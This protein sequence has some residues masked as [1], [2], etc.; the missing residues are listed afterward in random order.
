M[1]RKFSL[2]ALVAA[3]LLVGGLSVGSASAA[4]L[5]GNCCADLE[6]RIAELEATTARKGNRKVSLTISGWVGEQVLWWDDGS[7][8]GTYVTGLGTT[9]ASHVTFAGQATIM[10]GWY[11][12]YVLQL[13]MDEADPLTTM[14]QNV[15][16]GPTSIAP[17]MGTPDVFYS[18]WFVKSDHLGKVSV[19]LQSSAGDNAAI[20]VD[21]SGSLV[22]ANWVQ[23]DN[24][25][26]FIR[27]KNG[28]LSSL[29]WG[30]LGFCNV[31]FGNAGDCVG[32]PENLVR[33][34][35]PT[36]AGFSVSADWGQDSY[37]DVYARYSG[38]YNGIKV[39]AVT[40]WSQ[41][42]GCHGNQTQGEPFG[43]AG[44]GCIN[45]P[46]G[47]DSDGLNPVNV[48][49]DVGYWQSGLYVE[50]VATG[51]WVL[52]NYGREHLSDMPTGVNG[53]F[54][55]TNL[56]QLNSNPDHWYIKAGLRERWSQLGHTV[57]Y[58]FYGDRRDMIGALAV[59]DFNIV[60]SRTRQYGL[61]VVQEVDAAAMSFWLQWDHEKASVSCGTP[62]AGLTSTNGCA[63]NGDD[64]GATNLGGG[65]DAI[66]IV[67]G[68][69][70]IN[71]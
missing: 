49:G 44:S 70:L 17:G 28:A 16:I 13:E 62:Q 67:K 1:M 45:S 30:S 21:G 41:T 63:L 66:N 9:L 47:T 59:E 34:D 60:G 65:F 61:G 18:Y 55:L 10:P 15:N 25:A 71:F 50:H 38:E 26:F 40:G 56:G 11:A 68:G 36:W 46:F 8:K 52:A 6:E 24:A 39:A 3:G 32:T 31:G 43:F 22:P 2:S 20:L 5:G 58:G 33:Y 19:G 29:T 53:D 64:V 14:S 12:G 27:G 54:P 42:N 57:L 4:D 37:W 7:A 51:L 48:S 35:S 23:F 69:A